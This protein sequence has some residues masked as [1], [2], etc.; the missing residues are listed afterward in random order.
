VTTKS[1]RVAKRILGGTLAKS[2]W[3][4]FIKIRLHDVLELDTAGLDEPE[5]SL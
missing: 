2:G 3:A 4:F 5:W 1:E